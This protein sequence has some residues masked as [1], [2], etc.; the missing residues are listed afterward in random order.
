MSD[1][2]I[3]K[4]ALANSLKDIM[5]SIPLE[6]I[7]VKDIVENCKLN[8]QTF[9]YH[10]KD[11]FDLVNWIYY[12]EVIEIMVTQYHYENWDDTIHT[13]LT[14][15]Q[16][17]KVFYRNALNNFGQNSF[18]EYFFTIT[19]KTLFFVFDQLSSDFA[20]S[21]EDK[22]FCADFYAY[23]CTGMILQWAH[24]NM[25]S[26]PDK[27]CQSFHLILSNSIFRLLDEKDYVSN[28]N[29]YKLLLL[30]D[31]SSDFNS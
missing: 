7:T 4:A 11:K 9:Y 25:E 13:L 1:S 31:F 23:A 2:N 18:Y 17:D 6:K 24:N 14:L 22:S 29:K 8:R 19:K 20:M 12:T 30:N 28:Q 3:T 16:N 15:L 21:P 27:L 10:F 26:S 5:V